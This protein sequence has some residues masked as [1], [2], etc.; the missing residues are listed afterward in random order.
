[1]IDKLSYDEVL[2]ISNELKKEAE[3]IKTGEES[4]AGENKA[5]HMGPRRR[6]LCSFFYPIFFPFERC[7]NED[8]HGW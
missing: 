6:G 5:A 7:V 4:Q 2:A 1:M 3:T 8:A